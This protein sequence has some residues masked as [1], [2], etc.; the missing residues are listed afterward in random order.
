MAGFA[1]NGQEGQ[2]FG[3]MGFLKPL[4]CH[5]RVGCLCANAAGQGVLVVMLDIKCQAQFG[6]CL[7]GA[8][9]A[10]D[11]EGRRYTFCHFLNEGLKTTGLAQIVFQAGYI[12][13]PIQSFY[14]LLCGA[15]FQIATLITLNVHFQ[16]GGAGRSFRPA[17]QVGEE[18]FGC[19]VQSVGPNV[20]VT[21]AR[22]GGGMQVDQCNPQSL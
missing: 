11:S 6:P 16:N 12:H 19:H 5:L 17:A 7:T 14:T 1:A 18:L 20:A 13:H 10:N 22:I 2:N 21:Q 8:A 4:A 15:E 9:F 3:A